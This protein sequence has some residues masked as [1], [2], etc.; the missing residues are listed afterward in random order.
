MTN[1]FQH[2]YDYIDSYCDD[3]RLNDDIING[4]IDDDDPRLQ[5]IES[6]KEVRDFIEEVYNLAF[7]HDSI[8]RDWHPDAVIEELTSF[9]DKALEYDE[10]D[11][12]AT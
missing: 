4:N 9:S 5:D 3:D 10:C 12:I 8:N 1:H 6:L 7:G 2:F 11:N